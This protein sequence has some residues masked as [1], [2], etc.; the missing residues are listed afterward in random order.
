MRGRQNSEDRRKESEVIIEFE[1]KNRA[2]V[3][4]I[5]NNL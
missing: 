3:I 5:E 1:L 4:F 2:L